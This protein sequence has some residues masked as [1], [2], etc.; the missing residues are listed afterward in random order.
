VVALIGCGPDSTPFQVGFVLQRGETN[1]CS[2]DSCEAIPISCPVAMLVR[3]ADNDDDGVAYLSECFYKDNEGGGDSLCSIADIE[4]PA[5]L[6]PNEMVK[7]QIAVW[8]QSD[9]TPEMVLNH[10]CPSIGFDLQNTPIAEPTPM[11]GGQA[12]FK[13]GSS[14]VADVTLQCIN[15]TDLNAPACRGFTDH[16]T[17]TVVELSP[18]LLPV[19]EAKAADLDVDVVEPTPAPASADWLVDPDDIIPMTLG[20]ISPLP[21]WDTTLSRPFE[22]ALCVQVFDHAAFGVAH[23]IECVDVDDTAATKEGMLVPKGVLD[24]LTQAI[25]AIP[26]RGVVLGVVLD[27]N[28]VPAPGITVS[29]T[30]G[31]VKYLSVDLTSTANSIGVELTETTASGAFVSTDVQFGSATALTEWRALNAD[32]VNEQ[33]PALGGLVRGKL[34]FVK[35][36]MKPF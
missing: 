36:V 27:S 8:L 23:S 26:E 31:T 16:V 19:G 5:E 11:L 4:L 18:F 35:L 12:Y 30:L 25:G 22:R 6:I 9:L 21:L 32:G 29:P 34:T 28:G 1:R 10:E 14:E 20:Q 15:E 7:V 24:A 2:S 3:I 13:V 17:A 33:T